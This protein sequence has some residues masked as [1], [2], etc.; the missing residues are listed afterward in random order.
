MEVIH[1]WADAEAAAILTAVRRVAP[2]GATV[3]VIEGVADDGEVDPRVQTLDVVMLTITGGRERTSGQF[4]KLLDSVG[5][6]LGKV[7]DTGG[8]L[9]IVEATVL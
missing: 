4:A 5:L 1:D 9:R 2:R 3:L 8:P 6:R 7:V